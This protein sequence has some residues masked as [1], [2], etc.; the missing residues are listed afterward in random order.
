MHSLSFVKPTEVDQIFDEVDEDKDGY[1]SFEEHERAAYRYLAKT[2][3]EETRRYYETLLG[4]RKYF[5]YFGYG[6]NMS[7]EGMASKGLKPL[8]SFRAILKDYRLAFNLSVGSL[9]DPAFANVVPS[10]GDEVH[11]ICIVFDEPDILKLDQQEAVYDRVDCQLTSYVEDGAHAF[12]GQVY[13]WTEELAIKFSQFAKY[14][15][16]AP[17]QRYLNMLTSGGKKINLDADYISKLEAHPV[18]TLPVLADVLDDEAKAMINAKQFSLEEVEATAGMDPALG[19][20]RGVVVRYGGMM[21]RRAGGKDKTLT[22]CLRVR[23]IEDLIQ[24]G[25]DHK[26]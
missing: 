7:A 18:G 24:M 8:N 1:I 10:P 2:G 17:S 4:I 26:D 22:E 13:V 23:V 9:C 14:E 5:V 20:C 21:A 25:D 19:V 16:K 12:L 3:E 11:G 6:S 15:E